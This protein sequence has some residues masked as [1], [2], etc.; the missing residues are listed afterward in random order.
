MNTPRRVDET[1]LKEIVDAY[2]R[3]Y[4]PRARAEMEAFR[5]LPLL[6]VAIRDAALLSPTN[7]K[8]HSHQWKIPPHVLRAAESKLQ[9]AKKAIRPA[10][11]FDALHAII[12]GEIGRID[13][14]GDLV[15]YDVAHRVGAFLRKEPKRV[16]LHRGTAEGAKLLGFTGP[17]VD[18]KELPEAFS[19]LTAAEIE[20]CLCVYKSHLSGKTP[21]QNLVKVFLPRQSDWRHRA[22]MALTALA[23]AVS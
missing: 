4:R 16:Y 15:V 2:I 22:P 5:R 14:V 17:T 19:R 21:A 11:D 23:R 7:G 6:E 8:K 1:I 13:G 18:P 20:D 10:K 9:A 12:Q 3:D